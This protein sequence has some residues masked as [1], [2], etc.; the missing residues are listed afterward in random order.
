[1][2]FFGAALG[3]SI[4]L[5]TLNSVNNFQELFISQYYKHAEPCHQEA[6]ITISFLP[7]GRRV[8]LNYSVPDVAS[9]E[10]L[11]LLTAF[12]YLH[13]Y[14]N[15]VLPSLIGKGIPVSNFKWYVTTNLDFWTL[16][17][18]G[19]NLS[20]DARVFR[21]SPVSGTIQELPEQFHL[22]GD[23][24]YGSTTNV[25]VPYRDTGHLDRTQLFNNV[26]FYKGC[27]G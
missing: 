11:V 10:W 1:M 16:E 4:C 15:I 5:T 12:L 21:N 6:V 8:L 22:L 3:I 27:C 14:P 19:Q 7:Q 26:C 25:L 23:S 24:A 13:P 20:H 17:Q 18:V 9:Q 2:D